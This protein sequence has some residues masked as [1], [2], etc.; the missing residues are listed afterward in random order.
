M[1]L[2]RAAYYA[3]LAVVHIANVQQ[4]NRTRKKELSETIAS[5]DI[6]RERHI[7]D[8][9]L[10]KVLKPLVAAQILQSVKGPNGGYSLARPPHEIT[11]LEVIEAADQG[12][13]RG[14]APPVKGEGDVALTRRLDQICNQIAEQTR[15]QLGKIRITDLTG[16]D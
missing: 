6:A 4:Q 12:Q 10:L 8:R 1:K 13:I 2:T 14:S 15:K 5:H 11:L 16:K 3:I 9:F 7:P